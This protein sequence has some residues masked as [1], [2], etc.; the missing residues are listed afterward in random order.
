LSQEKT[1]YAKIVQGA[2]AGLVATLPMTLFM[3]SA[4]KRLPASEQYVLPPRQITRELIGSRRFRRLGEGN[5]TLITLLL[6]FL[7]GAAA[8]SG[9]GIVQENIPLSNSVKGPLAGM[10]LWVGSY[11]GWLPAFGVLSPATQHPWRLNLLMIVAH[12]IWGLVLGTLAPV[13]SSKN[14]YITM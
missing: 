11:L 9:Y 2:A 13:R 12:L 4:W 14:T 7:Y 3:I 5:K 6:H 8:G 10:A 1:P